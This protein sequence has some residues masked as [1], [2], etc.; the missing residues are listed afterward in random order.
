[1][2]RAKLRDIGA[3]DYGL[4]RRQRGEDPHHTSAEIARPLVDALQ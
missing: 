4:S 1:M 2:V 3:D